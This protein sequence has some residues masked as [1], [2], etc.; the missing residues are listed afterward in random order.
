MT[1]KE[2]D[3]TAELEQFKRESDRSIKLATEAGI[4]V[5]T[6]QWLTIKRYAQRYNLTTQVVTNWL[7]RGVIPEDCTMVLPE[8]NDLRLVKDQHYK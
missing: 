5:D 8:L 4:V 2:L 1:T 3:L 7:S 6:A